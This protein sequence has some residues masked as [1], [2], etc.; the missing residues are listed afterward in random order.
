MLMLMLMLPMLMRMLALM[1][2]ILVIRKLA[3]TIF[4]TFGPYW[5]CFGKLILVS[6]WS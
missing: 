5:T 2:L 3:K 4:L 6:V 1:L